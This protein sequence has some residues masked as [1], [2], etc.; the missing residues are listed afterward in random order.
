M[1]P[2]AALPLAT[3]VGPKIHRGVASGGRLALLDSHLDPQR[4][5]GNHNDQRQIFS[6]LV[7]SSDFL[8]ELAL[9]SRIGDPLIMASGVPR[10]VASCHRPMRIC[11]Q[12]ASARGNR[13]GSKRPQHQAHLDVQHTARHE[14][15][16]NISIV[17]Q[18]TTRQNSRTSGDSTV[19]SRMAFV[20]D[21][22][23]RRR[24]K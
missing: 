13:G 21:S 11:G 18:P 4:Q 8:S 12:T 6:R 5:E 1:V 10:H 24:L 15:V 22:P 19:G 14:S 17:G 20:T 9:L 3:A 2:D 23:A 7:Q 16:S